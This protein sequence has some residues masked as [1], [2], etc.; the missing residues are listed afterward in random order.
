MNEHSFLS[1]AAILE[2]Q[3]ILYEDVEVP[4]WGGWVRV[5]SLTGS[6]RDE[7][8]GSLFKTSGK[9]QKV[10]IS[11]IRAKLVA[12]SICDEAGARVFTDQD[13][14]LLG[15]KSAAALD[16]VYSVAQRLSRVSNEDVDE[17]AGNSE[18][19]LSVDS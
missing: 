6:E 19:A 13:I 2:A 14:A 12:K 15:R 16:R 1:R 10:D 17:L 5:K 7:F 4:E 11:D 18:A 9:I 3:D 8:E